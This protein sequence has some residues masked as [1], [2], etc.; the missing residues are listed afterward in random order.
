MRHL[1]PGRSVTGADLEGALRSFA[2]GRI[3]LSPGEGRARGLVLRTLASVAI[4]ASLMPVA[5][6][7]EIAYLARV[8]AAHFTE[9]GDA[10]AL[11]IADDE[12][13]LV[14]EAAATG[15]EALVIGE[16]RDRPA[17]AHRVDVADA[18]SPRGEISFLARVAR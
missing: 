17:D 8:E 1:T 9:V 10:G 5:N 11:Q 7:A 12:R 18:G 2:A 13:G 15:C 14:A 16:L 6:P 3:R 4:S